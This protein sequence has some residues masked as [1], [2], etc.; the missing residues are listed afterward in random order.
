MT[1]LTRAASSIALMSVAALV[2][3]APASATEIVVFSESFEN[4]TEPSGPP[5]Y[6]DYETATGADE[7][8]FVNL[9]VNETIDCPGWT[10]EG[11]AWITTYDSG[12]IFPDGTHAAWLNEGPPEEGSILRE[13]TGLTPGRD[14][15]LSL[16][17]WTDD[18]DN[19]TSL[20]V[21]VTN[22]SDVTAL[23]YKLR[24]GQGIQAL[25]RSFSATGNTVTIKLIGSPETS[26]SPLVD[27]IRIL[28]AGDTAENDADEAA[29]Q[30]AEAASLAATGFDPIAALGVAGVLVAAGAG[31]M[32]ARRRASRD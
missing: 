4:C 3:V 18:Q 13:I 15:A 22:G 1:S 26:A 17:T 25:T 12:G 23:T 7:P 28:D 11:Q 9:W 20:I 19:P 30:E 21:E 8:I 16:E 32:I 14:Y 31:L 10:A 27:N 2:S 24:R 6:T 29:E 5:Q